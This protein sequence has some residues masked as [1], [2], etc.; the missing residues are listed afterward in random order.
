M[1]EQSKQD[2]I[3]ALMIDRL[4][5][6]IKGEAEVFFSYFVSSTSELRFHHIHDRASAIS[7]WSKFSNQP[8]GGTTRIGDMV[9]YVKDQ[10]ENRHKLHNLDIDL[11]AEKPEILIVNDGQD[12]VQTN[13]FEYKVN[14]ITLE[15]SEND[16]L[17]KLSL[18]TKG[19]YVYIAGKTTKTYSESGVQVMKN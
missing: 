13:K 11:S 10:I 12:D 8:N 17:K 5:Y 2:W 9:N 3:N 4:R 19:K 14:A 18:E 1:G 6:C 15:D 16:G 7:F